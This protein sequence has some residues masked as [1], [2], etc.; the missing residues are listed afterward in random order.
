MDQ[1]IERGAASTVDLLLV[2]TIVE[3]SAER[4]THDQLTYTVSVVLPNQTVPTYF[5]N[6]APPA[7]R[8]WAVPD[9]DPTDPLEFEAFPLASRVL[10][11]CRKVSP[12]QYETHIAEREHPVIGPCT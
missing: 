8:R 11:I 10:V 4:G 2:G 3:R 6:V 12:T 9:D 1:S 7:W 5:E